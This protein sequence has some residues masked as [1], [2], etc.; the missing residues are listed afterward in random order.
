MVSPSN[1][2]DESKFLLLKEK[3]GRDS[4]GP[5]R[6]ESWGEKGATERGVR[7][8]GDSVDPV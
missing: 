1:C 6:E 5:G 4:E 8:R 3:T 7:R 2:K